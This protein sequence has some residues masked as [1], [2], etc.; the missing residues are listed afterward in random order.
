MPD[1]KNDL[2]LRAA[3]SNELGALSALC[4]RSKAV[5]GYDEAFMNACRTELTLTAADLAESRVH[6]AERRGKLAGVAQVRAADG[7]AHLEKLFVEPELLRAGV[8]GRL[9]AWAVEA[10]RDFGARTL[11][12]E[13]D[14]GAAE[15]YRRMGARDDGVAPSGSIAGRFLRRLR[16]DLANEDRLR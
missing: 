15:F 6:V 4:L 13:S 7:L 16:F 12:I 14:P 3:R 9:F 2:H 10:A 1:D 11:V 5:W 8:G